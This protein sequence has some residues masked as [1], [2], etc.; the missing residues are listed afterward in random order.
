MSSDLVSVGNKK[1]VAH[2]AGDTKRHHGLH[3]K[4]YENARSSGV[5]E[6][7]GVRH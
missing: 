3:I 6:Q 7:F 2:D 5:T 4:R 1:E